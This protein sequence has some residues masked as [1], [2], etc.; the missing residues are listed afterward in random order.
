MKKNILTTI[1]NII[2]YFFSFAALV[3]PLRY[4][5]A[6]K[7][8][9]FI[10]L[11]IQKNYLCTREQTIHSRN[12]LRNSGIRKLGAVAFLLEIFRRCTG[13]RY[14][15]AQD[16][17]V[18]GIYGSVVLVGE[19]KYSFEIFFIAKIACNVVDYRNTCFG[20]L[21]SLHICR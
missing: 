1:T 8:Y 3:V 6:E 5:F 20:K 2:F 14:F 17:M 19:A 4:F 13:C 10:S 12:N 18:G 9:F 16:Y 7:L 21:G 15:G 11:L